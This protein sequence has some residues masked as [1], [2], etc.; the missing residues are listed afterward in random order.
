MAEVFSGLGVPKWWKSE[1]GLWLP[2]SISDL[3]VQDASGTAKTRF[4]GLLFAER[5]RP[6][7]NVGVYA[8]PSAV[9]VAPLPFR[10]FTTNLASVPLGM[11]L[12]VV[13]EVQRVLHRRGMDPDMQLALAAGL[14]AGTPAF[15]PLAR[16]VTSIR[17]ERVAFCEQA[18][19]FLQLLAL[20]VCEEEPT[21]ISDDE[22]AARIRAALFFAPGYLESHGTS[23]DDDREGWLR[24]LIQLFDYNGNPVFGN[25]LGRTWT[26]FG[27][28]HREG[29][30]I[31]PAVPLDDWLR[32]DYGLGLEQQL[33]LGFALFAHLSANGEG[34]DDIAFVLTAEALGGIFNSLDFSEEE[35]VAAEALISAPPSWFR[36]QVE[37]ESPE[38]LQWNRVPFMRRPFVRLPSGSYF[39]QSPRAL[40]SWIADGTH[41][42]CLDAAMVRDAVVEYTARIGKLTE[43]YVLELVASAHQEPRLP[44]AGKVHGDK[45]FGRG[46]D[47]SDVTITYPHEVVLMEVSSHRLTVEAR[48]GSD[49]EAIEKDL[50][51]MV[52]RRPKQLRRSIDAIKPDRRGVA[53]TLRY[54]RLDPSRVARFWPL[55]ITMTPLH[56]SPLMED[57]LTPSLAELNG[58]VDVEPLDVLAVEDLESL[59]AITEQTG[60][61]LADLLAA[62]QRSSGPHADVRTWL[63]RDHS[64]PNL[65]RSAYL[66]DALHEALD[67]AARLLGFEGIRDEHAA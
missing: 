32:E 44:H 28:L 48:C 4:N 58:R 5:P 27:R 43:R 34:D 15:E 16:W 9:G 22:Y 61:R 26:I 66:D 6:L 17:G 14:F 45:K 2:S 65:A 50:E 31:R 13:C 35:C 62:K 59:V 24:H 67:T 1:T 10:E 38:R 23:P 30:D 60:A 19:T 33:S 41:Y 7:G 57:F 54:E 12:P 36:A 51:E 8:T 56:W 46:I 37:G 21:G 40:M 29:S 20:L 18:M 63:D 11:I 64:F 47:S 53:A 55:I 3:H 49:Q 52:G 25:A 39:L 42:R